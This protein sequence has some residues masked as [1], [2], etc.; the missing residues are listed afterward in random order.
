MEQKLPINWQINIAP[1]D[2]QPKIFEFALEPSQYSQVAN[3]LNI[4]AIKKLS[5]KITVQRNHAQKAVVKGKINTNLVQSCIISLEDISENL[6]IIFERHL[7]DNIILPDSLNEEDWENLD[8]EQELWDGK[9]INLGEII[10]EE[11]LI[12][13]NPYPR[14][15]GVSFDESNSVE[16]TFNIKEDE[17]KTDNPFAILKDLKLKK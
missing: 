2:K 4:V 7:T 10:L 5:A 12:N 9:N 8:D 1:N 11:I 14:K 13:K 17:V 16:T 6:N 3:W 15:K